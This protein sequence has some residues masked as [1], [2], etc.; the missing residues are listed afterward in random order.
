MSTKVTPSRN[1]VLSSTVNFEFVDGPN[2]PCL[3]ESRTNTLGSLNKVALTCNKDVKS[4][5]TEETR[6][7]AISRVKTGKSSL[8]SVNE[9][10]V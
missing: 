9:R 10:L 5:V 3:G 8:A 1:N 4:C 7:S 2:I 6:K